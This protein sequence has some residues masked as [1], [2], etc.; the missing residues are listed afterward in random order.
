MWY[1]DV[2]LLTML[3]LMLLCILDSVGCMVLKIHENLG[4]A[5]TYTNRGYGAFL[6]AKPC[7]TLFCACATDCSGR[8]GFKSNLFYNISSKALF[9]R[10]VLPWP[11]PFSFNMLFVSPLRLETYCP[12]ESPTH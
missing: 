6:T 5:T 4:I 1:C 8:G 12:N 7:D 10:S 11:N 2:L 3:N 9:H